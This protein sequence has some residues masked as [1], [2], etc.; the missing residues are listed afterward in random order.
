MKI[1]LLT[2]IDGLGNKGDIVDV[3]PGYAKHALIL[4]KKARI[5]TP[6]MIAHYNKNQEQK[7]Q[8]HD[9]KAAHI[10]TLIKKLKSQSFVFTLKGGE[11][12]EVFTS[13][14]SQDIQKKIGT[15]LS[16]QD[17]SFGEKDV[18][19]DIKPIKELGT[20]EIPLRIGREDYITPLSLTITIE[21][22]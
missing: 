1:Q 14:H 8:E 2:H 15:Y 20:H 7:K 4:K 10:E 11:K 22:E 12:G 18:H 21:K 19:V 16:S 5:A 9:A 6:D 13:L 3:S 17:Q